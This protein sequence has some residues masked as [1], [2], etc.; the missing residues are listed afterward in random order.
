ML[1]KGVTL[2]PRIL[3]QYFNSTDPA[4]I[5]KYV[6]SRSSKLYEYVKN[7]EDAIRKE[8]NPEPVVEPK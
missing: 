6:E 5:E 3:G 7:N 1:E 8:L 4:D 2:D